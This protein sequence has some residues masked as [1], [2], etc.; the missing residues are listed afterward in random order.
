MLIG[1]VSAFV[2]L[3]LITFVFWRVTR[4]GRIHQPHHAAGPLAGRTYPLA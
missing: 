2:G 1:L 3:P 4:S